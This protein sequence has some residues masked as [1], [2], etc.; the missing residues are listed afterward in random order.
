M[1]FRYFDVGNGFDRVIRDVQSHAAKPEKIAWNLEVDNLPL[2]ICQK[3]IGTGPARNKNVSRLIRLPLMYQIASG[4][5]GTP[6]LVQTIQ[7][8]QFNI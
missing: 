5:K 8:G 7:H 1:N 2:A 6:T 3:F 4:D